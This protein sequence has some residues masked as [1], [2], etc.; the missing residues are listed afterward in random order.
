MPR[1]KKDKFVKSKE[2]Y[3]L[4]N[5]QTAKPDKKVTH[6]INNSIIVCLKVN[7]HIFDRIFKNK[8]KIEDPITTSDNNVKYLNGSLEKFNKILNSTE[9]M[10]HKL[11]IPRLFPES[12]IEIKKDVIKFKDYHEIDV[13]KLRNHLNQQNNYKR[14]NLVLPT[15]E[16]GWPQKSQ[17]SCWNCTEPFENTPVGIPTIHENKKS[18]EYRLEGNFCSYNCAARYI[19]D[20][21]QGTIL[22][23][24]Y[25]I[26]NLLYSQVSETKDIVTIPLA[27]PRLFLR[28]YGGDLGI[29][30][31]RRGSHTNREFKLYRYPL[32]P[33]PYFIEESIP[34]DKSHSNTV[35]QDRLKE[36]DSKYQLYRKKPL[37]SK[38]MSLT[39]C[40][41]IKY[42]KKP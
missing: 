12:N 9:L 18:V 4:V 31:Y 40:M 10:Y 33:C 15:F 28:K 23:Q 36:L 19:F 42:K 21:E 3:S 25:D 7:R 27:P 22:Y 24:K 20:T 8:Q 26:L 34:I 2:V 35:E 13:G 6:R 29:D 30:E 1:V 5:H 38:S 41:D 16:S 11:S 32:K 39:K 14:V 17:Y 37:P